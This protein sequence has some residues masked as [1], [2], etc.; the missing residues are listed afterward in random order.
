MSFVSR[1]LHAPL[2]IIGQA[3]V[4]L[5]ALAG[6]VTENVR[7][8][9]LLRFHNFLPAVDG[10]TRGWHCEPGKAFEHWNG[11]ACVARSCFFFFVCLFMKKSKGQ[12]TNVC[13][14][15]HSTSLRR[16][17]GLSL[18][19]SWRA[20]VCWFVVAHSVCRVISAARSSSRLV[21]CVGIILVRGPI[22]KSRSETAV[23]SHERE[24]RFPYINVKI[25]PSLVRLSK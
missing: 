9:M 23:W 13:V 25:T 2:K 6:V 19:R 22:P 15:M 3:A 17:S 8:P 1:S 5:W 21:T 24:Q 12:K 11:T 18:L 10:Q 7:F 4:Y 14:H 16:C 20:P